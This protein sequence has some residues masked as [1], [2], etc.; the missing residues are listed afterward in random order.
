MELEL[1]CLK[2]A[3]FDYKA[4][5][6]LQGDSILASDDSVVCELGLLLSDGE[7]EALGKLIASAPIFLNAGI[8]E[9]LGSKAFDEVQDALTEALGDRYNTLE[10]ECDEEDEEF[11]EEEDEEFDEEED[12]EFED[13]EDDEEDDS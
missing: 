11:D 13:E 7:K 8:M 10:D 6:R 12:E 5:W 3:K 1:S 2:N 4:P 9:T